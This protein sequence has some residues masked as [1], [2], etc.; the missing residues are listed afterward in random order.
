MNRPEDE[1]LRAVT[2][3]IAQ[4]NARGIASIYNSAVAAW[5]I[6]AAWEIGALDE[7]H[8]ARTLDTAEFAERNGLDPQST[9]GLFRAL[10]AVGLVARDGAVVRTLDGFDDMYRNKS[11]FHWLTRGSAELFRQIPSVL[12]TENRTGDDCHRDPAA[13]AYACRE[14][15][16][17]TYAPTFWAAVDRVDFP[18]TRVAD[19]GCGS[20]VVGIA[21]A[22]SE[23]D[24]ELIFTDESYPA[25]ASAEENFRA[26]VGEGR[27]AEFVV[28]DGLTDLPAG[29]VD[30]VLNNPPFHSHQATTDRTARRMFADA[31]RAL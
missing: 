3:D 1:V 12:R 2:V 13:I 8:R 30:L 11:F 10:S 27:K 24:A 28:G 25:V 16:Q 31:R 22:L 6:A 5:A 18:F 20:G 23:P 7:L 17:V 19:L 14:I 15:D 26:H 9:T 29:S 4:G 21:I